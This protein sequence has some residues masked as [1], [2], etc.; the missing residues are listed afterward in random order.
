MNACLNPSADTLETTTSEI[1][2]FSTAGP[3]NGLIGELEKDPCLPGTSSEL[4]HLLEKK[5]NLRGAIPI[6]QRVCEMHDLLEGP[7]TA[8]KRYSEMVERIRQLDK[9]KYLIVKTTEKFF[10]QGILR[11]CQMEKVKITT[12]QFYSKGYPV[13]LKITRR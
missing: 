5:L 12:R 3:R 10:Q 11:A 4:L 2:R 13:G 6:Y 9:G 7:D 8:K 1:W